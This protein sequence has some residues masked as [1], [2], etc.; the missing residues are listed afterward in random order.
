MDA[1]PSWPAAP[2]IWQSYVK[3]LEEMVVSS[4]SNPR[5]GAH[6]FS[7]LWQIM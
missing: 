4:T 6:R 5:P 3:G 7:R 1:G 2:Q